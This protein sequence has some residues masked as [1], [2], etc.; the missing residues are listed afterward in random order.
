MP[1]GVTSGLIEAVKILDG[2]EGIGIV[3]LEAMDVIRHD[4]VTRIVQAYDRYEKAAKAKEE[5]LAKKKAKE[6][7]EKLAKAADEAVDKSPVKEMNKD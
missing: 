2:V 3:R 6:K 7:A 4:V 1:R 5:R